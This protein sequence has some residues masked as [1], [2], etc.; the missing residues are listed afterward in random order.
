MKTISLRQKRRNYLN[1]TKNHYNSKNRSVR[2][3][4]CLYSPAHENTEGCA[5]GRKIKDKKLCENLDRLGRDG[6]TGVSNNAVFAKFPYDLK[7]LSQRFLRNMQTLHDMNENWDSMGLTKLGK[8]YV[9]LIQLKYKL[10]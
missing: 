7:N 4:A 1:D 3:G 5:I 2:A 6:S 9:K 8:S 10:V